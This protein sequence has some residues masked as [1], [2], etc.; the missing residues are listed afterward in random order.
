MRKN[1]KVK[2]LFLVCGIL[3]L[4]LTLAGH[5]L[6]RDLKVSLGYLPKIAESPEKGEFVDLIKAMDEVYTKGNIQIKVFPINR[7]IDNV[8]QGKADFHM[9]FLKNPA[10][11]LEKMP[12]RFVSVRIGIVPF[13]I[14]SHRENPI[15]SEKLERAKSLRTFPYKIECNKGAEEHFGIPVIGSQDIGQS[16]KKAA[17]LLEMCIFSRTSLQST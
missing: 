7:S 3:S 14:F 6:C 2:K 9:P 11:P 17:T 10:A 15:T 8:I 16:M 12:F 5:A 4:V 1:I 13:V